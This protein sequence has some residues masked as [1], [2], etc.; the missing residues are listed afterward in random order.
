MQGDVHNLGTMNSMLVLQG[1]R[2]RIGKG[3]SSVEQN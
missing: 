1:K 3:S 2:E